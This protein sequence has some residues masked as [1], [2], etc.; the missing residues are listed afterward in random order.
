MAEEKKEF[1][2]TWRYGPDEQAM[3]C[4]SEDEIPEG[5]EDHPS[6]VKAPK[7]KPEPKTKKKE[8]DL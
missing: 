5:W 3:I 6:K 7:P 2:P 4:Y 1:V 8:L